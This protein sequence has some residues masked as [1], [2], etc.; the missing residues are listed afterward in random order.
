MLCRW[1]RGTPSSGLLARPGPSW[2][3]GTGAV[4]G[5]PWQAGS[6]GLAVYK[7]LAHAHACSP[8]R[9]GHLEPGRGAHLPGP[10]S[11]RC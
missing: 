7:H 4:G 5:P 1:P 11:L 9:V 6:L 2:G 10:Q 3:R 8:F